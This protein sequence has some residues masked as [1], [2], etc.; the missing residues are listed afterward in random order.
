MDNDPRRT[1]TVVGLLLL[2]SLT[3][4]VL[5]AHVSSGSPVEPMRTAVGDVLGPV[6]H[7]TSDVMRPVTNLPSHFGD[8]SDL[9]TRNAALQQQNALLRSQLLAQQAN[10]KRNVEVDTIGAFAST[11]GYHI[12][13]AQVVAMGPAQSFTRTVTIDA[14]TADGVVPDLTVLNA[15]GLVGRVLTASA[16]SATVLLAIDRGSIVGGRLASSLQLGFLHGTGVL[17]GG[18]ALSFSLIDHQVAPRVGQTVL[19]WGSEHDAPYLPGIPVGRVVSVQSTPAELTETAI[20][21]PFVDF[22][23]LDVVGIVVGRTGSG[24]TTQQAS[25]SA[26]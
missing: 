7:A 8:V 5:D 16:H 21:Q 4:M 15:N 2:A 1:R 3:V 13:Q 17:S 25:G 10:A 23:S 22:T 6:E 26:R 11:H 12:V 24:S 18:G 20:V 9:R 19:T 14:G